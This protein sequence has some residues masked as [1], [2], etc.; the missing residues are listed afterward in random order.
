LSIESSME[1]WDDEE[2]VASMV[3]IAV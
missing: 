1:E 3:S 2:A